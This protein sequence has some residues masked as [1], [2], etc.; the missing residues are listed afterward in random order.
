VLP[1]T[2]KRNLERVCEARGGIVPAH[3]LA[4][5]SSVLGSPNLTKH[6]FLQRVIYRIVRVK[7]AGPSAARSKA[8][9]CGR[10]PGEIVGLNPTGDMVVSLL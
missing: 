3:N 9:V 5:A 10:S 7:F 4:G 1:N 2:L 6:K 8:W